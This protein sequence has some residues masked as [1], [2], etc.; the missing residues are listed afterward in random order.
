MKKIDE[1]ILWYEQNA[2]TPH[3]CMV[4]IELEKINSLYDRYKDHA[5]EM[6]VEEMIES[7]CKIIERQQEKAIALEDSLTNEINYNN[8]NNDFGGNHGFMTTQN[9]K[10]GQEKF[11]D[12]Q[13]DK[14]IQNAFTQ[15]CLNNG[16]S[17]YTVNDYCSRIK[18][19]WKSF[20]DDC[21]NG[22]LSDSLASKFPEIPWDGILMNV[23]Y[24]IEILAAYVR[25]KI[26]ETEGNRNWLN[27]RAALNKFDEFRKSI[28]K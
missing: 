15:Y 20:E 21:K 2:L 6:F 8:Y 4:S 25:G 23:Y 14:Q 17:S 22:K 24:N 18:K 27:A 3:D 16:S 28:E 1:L 26:A 10:R 9:F 7:F 19:T 13:D 11:E 5:N 12:F